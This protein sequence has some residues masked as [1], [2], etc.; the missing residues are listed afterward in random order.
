[1]KGCF[2]SQNNITDIY[3]ATSVMLSCFTKRLLGWH[4]SGAIGKIKTGLLRSGLS[5]PARALSRPRSFS[6]PRTLSAF[7]SMLVRAELLPAQ[8]LSTA[9]TH[10]LARQTVMT[11]EVESSYTDEPMTTGL[12]YR[13][14]VPK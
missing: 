2:M 12:S 8:H 13:L 6:I 1:M 11:T 7:W 3:V 10:P 9:E 4:S 5:W 14:A